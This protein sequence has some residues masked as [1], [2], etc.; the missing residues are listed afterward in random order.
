MHPDGSVNLGI[1]LRQFHC[2]AARFHIKSDDK[3]SVETLG[4]RE[5]V[6]SHCFA[7][8]IVKLGELNVCRA[9]R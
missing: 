1:F 4:G 6:L 2:T 8:R 3:H 7:I 5:R 9:N